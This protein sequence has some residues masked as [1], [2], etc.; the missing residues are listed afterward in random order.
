MADLET[1]I[2]R[3][4]IIQGE[5]ENLLEAALRD[6]AEEVVQVVSSPVGGVIGGLSFSGW[7][8]GRRGLPSQAGPHSA[9]LWTSGQISKLEWFIENT[10]DYAEFVH[11]RTKFGGPPGLADRVLPALIDEAAIAPLDHVSARLLALLGAP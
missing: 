11:R 3:L 4:G 9:D 5:L 8:R 2:R 7:P 10:A 6:I 1:E